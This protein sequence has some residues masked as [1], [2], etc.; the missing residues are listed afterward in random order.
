MKK[1]FFKKSEGF[2]SVIVIALLAVFSIMFLF[3]SSFI[4]IESKKSSDDFFKKDKAKYLAFA[5]TQDALLKLK[6]NASYAGNET[7]SVGSDSCQILAVQNLGG[8]QR[9]VK[10]QSTVE[11]YTKKIQVDVSAL[12]PAMAISSWDESPNF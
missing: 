10:T 11:I 9:V 12:T 7:I 3:G 1:I 2:V 8:E 5:C 6:T 4:G